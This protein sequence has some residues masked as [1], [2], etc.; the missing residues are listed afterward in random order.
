MDQQAK[1]DADN[2]SYLSSEINPILEPLTL[3]LVK[4]KPENQVS[5]Y[6]LTSFI[7]RSNSLLSTWKICLVK[8][9]LTVTD[10]SLLS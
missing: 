7:P 1:R 2:K 5:F 10:P 9:L 3:S 4:D 8:E 6:Y